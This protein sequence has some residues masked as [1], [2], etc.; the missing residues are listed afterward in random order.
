MVTHFD[1]L[2]LEHRIPKK[3]YISAH[4]TASRA[5]NIPKVRATTMS[6]R[7]NVRNFTG[8]TLPLDVDPHQTIS[9]VKKLLAATGKGKSV[10]IPA[11]A[12]R[13]H[14]LRDNK[15]VQHYDIVSKNTIHICELAYSSVV[16]FSPNIQ[17]N[18]TSASFE[19]E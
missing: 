13:G 3:G 5:P 18:P 15:Q 19:S 7:I 16:F 4:F 12:F 1:Q 17:W 10:R 11:L 14:E 2:E 6:I 8:T 9:E